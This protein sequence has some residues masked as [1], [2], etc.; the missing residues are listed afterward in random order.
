[1]SYAQIAEVLSLPLGTVKAR[2][3]RARLALAR[4]LAQVSEKSNAVL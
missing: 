4:S 2:L 3:N 1:M